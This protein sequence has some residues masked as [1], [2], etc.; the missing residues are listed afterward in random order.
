LTKPRLIADTIKIV[1]PVPWNR[2]ELSRICERRLGHANAT[3][4]SASASSSSSVSASSL[5]PTAAGLPSV[6]STPTPTLG[7]GGGDRWE[8]GAP[9][10][11]E[12]KMRAMN[13][14]IHSLVSHQQG[15]K[16]EQRLS[17]VGTDVSN[18]INFNGSDDHHEP[19]NSNGDSSDNSG[20]GDDSNMSSHDVRTRLRLYGE[21]PRYLSETKYERLAPGTSSFD[22]VIKM[23]RVAFQ[24]SSSVEAKHRRTLPQL[25]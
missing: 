7:A 8:R 9:K 20:S 24:P 4:T 18:K 25:V 22:N 21:M 17:V 16:K 1:D 14:M 11:K 10:D 6:G 5:A 12:K 15:K 19:V 2:V 3:A 13:Y 23:K